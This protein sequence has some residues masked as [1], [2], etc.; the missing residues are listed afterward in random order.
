MKKYIKPELI[1]PIIYKTFTMLVAA[2]TL[3]LLWDRLVNTAGYYSVRTHVLPIF[4]VL[5]LILAWFYF[6]R[7]DGVRL[8]RLPK[9]RKKDRKQTGNM[10]DA[11]GTEPEN[12][13][14]L[15]REERDFCSLAAALLSGVFCLVIGLF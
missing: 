13:E 12:D 8:L 2:A 1:R 7:L 3:A 11:I 6:L 9:S 15:S 5:F 10:M 4:G 14:E